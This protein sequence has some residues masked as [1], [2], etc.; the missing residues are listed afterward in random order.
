MVAR[1]EPPTSSIG[2][3]RACFIG[4]GE[5]MAITGIDGSLN[6]A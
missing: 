6:A 1:R 4:E 5:M 3:A 2:G